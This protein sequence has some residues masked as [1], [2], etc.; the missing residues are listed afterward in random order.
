MDCVQ[1]WSLDVRG[2]RKIQN[3]ISRNTYVDSVVSSVHRQK[4][5]LLI[6]N[7]LIVNFELTKSGCIYDYIEIFCLFRVIYDV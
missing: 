3:G 7:G 6:G 4:W 1:C 5:T 2:R